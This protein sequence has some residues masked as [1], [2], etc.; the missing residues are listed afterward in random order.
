VAV[1]LDGQTIVDL[2]GG[3]ADVARTRPWR[4]DTLVHVYSTTKGVVAL[5]AHLLVDR[6]LLDLDAPVAQYWPEFAAAGKGTVPVH[7]LLSHRVGLPAVRAPLPPGALFDWP[8]MTAALAAETPWWEPGTRFGYH[9]ITYGF[10][11][12]EVIRRVSGRSVGSLVRAEI[13][14]RL[15]VEFAIGLTAAE[16]LRAAEIV[17]LP[18]SDPAEGGPIAQALADPESMIGRMVFNPPMVAGMVNTH[19]YRAAEV[20]A[21]NGHT[22]ARAVARIYGCLARGGELEGVRLLRPE[23]LAHAV[24]EQVAGEDAALGWPTRLALGFMLRTPEWRMGPSP[25]AFGHPGAGGSVGFAD[26][27]ARL[28]FAY[29]PNRMSAL[30]RPE[31]GVRADALIAATYASL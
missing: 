13:A 6:G 23:T 14:R 17:P 31:L 3:H 25:R 28:G 15:G 10:L 2:W 29:T 12:G 30:V 7:H 26:P 24:Q 5:A 18:V 22:T 27:D 9:M 21:A 4:H 8:V 11:V 20:P 19:E 1:V 16:E